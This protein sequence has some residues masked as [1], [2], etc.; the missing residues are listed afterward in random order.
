MIFLKSLMFILWNVAIGLSLV[1]LLKWF[2]FN[3][4]PRKIFGWKIPLTPG[5]LVRKRDWLFSKARDLLHDYLRQAESAVNKNGYLARWEKM[6]YDV[7]WE[8]TSFIDEWAFLP[9]SFK[10][11]IHAKLSDMAK[12]IASSIL[13]KTVPHLIEEW[14]IEHRIDEYDFQF[15]IE[16]FYGYF[17]KYVYKP[18]LLTF[19]AINFLIGLSNMILYLILMAV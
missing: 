9:G 15:S 18:L 6:I 7:I 3:A 17:R 1:Y 8:K 2:L 16:F 13:R 5:F 10:S 14:R 19:L 12:G 11:K 4:R